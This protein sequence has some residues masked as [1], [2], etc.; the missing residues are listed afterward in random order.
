MPPKGVL[1][2]GEPFTDCGYAL[3]VFDKDLRVETANRF[4]I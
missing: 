1:P 3:L 2:K 4:S